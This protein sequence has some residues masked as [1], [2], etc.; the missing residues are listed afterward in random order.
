MRRPNYGAI[1]IA[2]A[3]ALWGTD[4][5]F[6]F[7]LANSFSATLVVLGEHLIVFPVALLLMIV[8]FRRIQRLAWTDWISLLVVAWGSSALATILFTESF[9]LVSPATAIL[10]Q[11][12][13]PLFAVAGA[14]ILLRE[15]LPAHFGLYAVVCVVGSYLVSFGFSP[16]G[17]LTAGSM[18]G[19]LFAVAAAALWGIGTVLGR[20]LLRKLQFPDLTAMRFVLALPLLAA[21]NAV[22]GS[23]GTIG[24]IT[25]I[26]VAMVI[27]LAL[28]PG[29]VSLLIYYLGL[30][31]VP[32]SVST[33]LELAY[34]ATGVLVSYLAFHQGVTLG[35][36]VGFALIW[37]MIGQFARQPASPVRTTALLDAG[38]EA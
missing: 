10:L 1:G 19:P 33:F 28:V 22:N 9:T 27:A 29:L 24:S 13:Q 18:T 17:A 6:R 34:P 14:R 31:R 21:I 2:F 37:L 23:F 3:A 25:A 32:A 15:R 4:P 11:K 12:L 36:A 38:G 20:S 16:I 30:E 35:Q 7:P 5:L 8:G 26:D